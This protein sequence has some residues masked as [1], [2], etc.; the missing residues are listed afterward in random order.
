MKNP[1]TQNPRPN[2]DP[3]R[4][5]SNRFPFFSF[6]PGWVI[7]LVVGIVVVFLLANFSKSFWYFEVIEND[8]V[9]VKIEA[10]KIQG[11][12]QPGIAYDFGL[13]VDLVK[14]TTSAVQL[15]WKIQS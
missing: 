14:I 15:R 6:I 10:G 12:V 4:P 3:S 2:I 13:F 11:I 5:L 1:N 7:G 9:G 8:Q